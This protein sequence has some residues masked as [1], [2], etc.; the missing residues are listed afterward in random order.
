MADE[1]VTSCL[2]W[3]IYTYLDILFL[4]WWKWLGLLAFTFLL[5]QIFICSST[6]ALIV[7]GANQGSSC[8][9]VSLAEDPCSSDPWP[10]E[11]CHSA[12]FLW[13]VNPCLKSI[14]AEQILIYNLQSIQKACWNRPCESCEGCG[15]EEKRSHGWGRSIRENQALWR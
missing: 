10:C 4:I 7:S 5:D 8:E 11:V 15:A 1:T 13:T 2:V 6:A 9:H 3:S 14:F 12:F